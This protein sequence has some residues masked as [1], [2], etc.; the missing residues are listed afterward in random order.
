LISTPPRWCTA[1][2]C[3]DPREPRDAPRLFKNTFVF[4]AVD[5]VRV[6]DLDEA[7]RHY[8]AWDSIVADKDQLDLS[9]HEL[10]QAEEQRQMTTLQ[11]TALVSERGLPATDQ[12]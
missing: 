11:A 9:P 2:G 12:D 4:L 8:F 3:R 10:K 6:Q 7:A 5:S 1:F